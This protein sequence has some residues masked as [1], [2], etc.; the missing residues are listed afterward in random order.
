MH[1]LQHSVQLVPQLFAFFSIGEPPAYVV[2]EQLFIQLAE[3]QPLGPLGL[4]DIRYGVGVG[5]N[6]AQGAILE[7]GVGVTMMR[8][9]KKKGKRIGVT[10]DN[11]NLPR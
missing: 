7:A 5:V 4:L 6:P 3:L 8:D 1:L 10:C 2:A 11:I 9:K